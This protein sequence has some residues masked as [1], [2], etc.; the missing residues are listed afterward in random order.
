MYIIT[1]EPM[2]TVTSMVDSITFRERSGP[3]V[4]CLA[5]DRGVARSS[6]TRATALWSLSKTHLS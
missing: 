5:Q 1:N 6:L 3:V 4:E 2:V